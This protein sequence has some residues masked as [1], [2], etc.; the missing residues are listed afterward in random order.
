MREFG[1]LI[2]LYNRV[3]LNFLSHTIIIKKIK[4][5]FTTNVEFKTH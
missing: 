1:V 3:Y 5:I 2:S 4:K